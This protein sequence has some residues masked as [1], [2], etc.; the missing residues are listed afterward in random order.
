MLT[1]VEDAHAACAYAGGVTNVSGWMLLSRE[2]QHSA[3]PCLR[4]SIVLPLRQWNLAEPGCPWILNSVTDSYV[5]DL[6]YPANLAK[7]CM[8]VAAFC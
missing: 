6:H 3:E 2:I 8:R 1:S 5:S 7:A 4:Q